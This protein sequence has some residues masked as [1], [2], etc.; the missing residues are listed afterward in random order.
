MLALPDFD[1]HY[2]VVCD[3]SGYGCGAVLLQ[4]QKPIAFQSYK[5]SDAEQRYPPGTGAAGCDFGTQAVEVLEGATGG[6]TVVTDHKPNT[7][8]DTKPS[9]QLSSR[10][11]HWQQSRFDFQWE[12]RK[13]ICNVA[14][15]VS[16]C[17]SLHAVTAEDGDSDSDA[18]VAGSVSVLRG[19][20]QSIRD[21]MC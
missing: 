12:Y 4:N 6:V 9:V 18:D 1:A 10:Q 20:L 11:V 14:D 19:F 2:E 7:F 21:A 8:L 15:P 5:L 13:G 16:R 17:P 3:A